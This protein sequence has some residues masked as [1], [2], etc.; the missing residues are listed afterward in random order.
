MPQEVIDDLF[1]PY[2]VKD[3]WM[4]FFN[5]GSQKAEID[6]ER[7]LKNDYSQV[8]LN[9]IV[10]KKYQ[11]TDKQ[12]IRAMNVLNR[13]FSTI[14]IKER[15]HLLNILFHKILNDK[16]DFRSGNCLASFAEA[17]LI[18]LDINIKD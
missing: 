12:L 18:V 15:G 13:G 17:L 7:A 6:I 16:F 5:Q 1:N 3:K 4:R 8:M 2:K 10:D 9:F 11:F 14:S